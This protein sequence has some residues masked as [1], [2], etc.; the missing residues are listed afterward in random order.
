MGAGTRFGLGRV[1]PPGAAG[2]AGLVLAGA[3]APAFDAASAAPAAGAPSRLGCRLLP[4]NGRDLGRAGRTTGGRRDLR[5]FWRRATKWG[6]FGRSGSAQSTGWLARARAHS[7]RSSSRR[8]EA[9]AG[10][11]SSEP[12]KT[13]T[14]RRRPARSRQPGRNPSFACRRRS[15]PRLSG[16]I[17]RPSM[18]RRSVTS[19]RGV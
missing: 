10:S 17:R 3:F 13:G 14:E 5:V 15:I 1:A 7:G 6:L 8:S 4:G 11:L 9:G 16:H 19:T 18:R 12:R 2:C